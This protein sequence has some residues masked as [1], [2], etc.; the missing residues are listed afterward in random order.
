MAEAQVRRVSFAEYT[1]AFRLPFISVSILAFVFGSLASRKG[2]LFSPFLLGLICAVST[3]LGANLIN[4]YADSKS[5]ADWQDIRPY[6]FFGGSKFIQLGLLEEGFYLRAALFCFAVAFSCVVS[7]AAITGR[8]S[9]I[10]FYLA[11]MFMGW[12][13]SCGPLRFSYRRLGEPVIFLLFGPALVMGGY[14]IQTGVFPDLKS[15]LL[16][17]P[18][19]FLTTAIL[20][21]NEIPDYPDDKKSAKNT[22]VSFLGQARS[23]ILYFALIACAFIAIGAS[24]ALGFLGW[25]A[26]VS[27]IFILPALAAGK[28]LK[29]HF[30]DKAK[31]VISSKLTIF[32]HTLVSITLIAGVIQR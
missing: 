8:L 13:Y 11:I 12:S 23:Y 22:W 4:D 25:Q 24:I 21:A 26:Y 31:L 5:G 3:H 10:L 2:F 20:F 9:T 15:F 7:L 29:D 18:M 6:K 32:V 16:S 27:F 28:I 30:A 14:F 19:G 17:L 1:S